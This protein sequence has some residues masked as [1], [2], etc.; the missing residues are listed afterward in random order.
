MSTPSVGID[1]CACFTIRTIL[2]LRSRRAYTGF[3]RVE[4]PGA[5]VRVPQHVSYTGRSPD[6]CTYA[7]GRL[8]TVGRRPPPDM[9]AAQRGTAD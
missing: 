8:V 5:L 3:S 6:A 2:L 1:E 9:G 4:T 7:F